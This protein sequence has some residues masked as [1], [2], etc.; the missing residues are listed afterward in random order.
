MP[1]LIVDAVRPTETGVAT[2]MNTVV[3]TVGGVIGAQVGA[4]LL[5]ANSAPGTGV[6][7]ESGFVDAFWIGAAGALVA[8]LAAVFARPRRGA[9]ETV[10]GRGGRARRR[11]APPA[12]PQGQPEERLAPAA[13]AR[14][15]DWRPRR[16]VASTVTASSS[17]APVTM[18]FTSES[19]AFRSMPFEMDPM[20]RA[21]RS[22]D[23]AVPRPPKRL[24]PP[25]TAAAIEFRSRSLA[26]G[27]L[28]D[29]EQ[30]RRGH[31]RRRPPRAWSTIAKTIRRIRVERDA[32]PARRLGVAAR[33]RRRA[34]RRPCGAG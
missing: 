13:Q 3:R 9:P 28:V 4:V 32:R 11:P 10:P 18:N 33:P 6:P 24:V 8:A 5:A 7:T 12:R 25:M 1:K 19:S 27:R 16:A 29:R 26:A 22:A 21:P 31:D 34:G 2:G 30:S 14:P 17:T 23:H 20:T 15:D